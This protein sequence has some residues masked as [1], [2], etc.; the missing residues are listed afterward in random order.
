MTIIL[1]KLNIFISKMLIAAFCDDYGV[2]VEKILMNEDW[3]YTPASD[4][5]SDGRNLTQK[6][7][8]DIFT[9]WIITRR[10]G[11]TR[12]GI[13]KVSRS[14]R[15]FFYLVLYFSGLGKIKDSE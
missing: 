9:R 4:K 15:T 10:K 5:F 11:F 12:A 14:V 8:P 1:V 3:F 2:N 6:S 7:L 13:E